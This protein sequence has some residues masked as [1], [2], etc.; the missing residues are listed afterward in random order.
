MRQRL[1]NH[2]DK[3]E[4][5]GWIPVTKLDHLV[6][7]MKIKSLKEIYHFSSHIR[8]SKIIDCFLGAFFKDEVLKI[9]R[10]QK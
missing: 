2:G 7:D 3:I 10:M 9:L 4:D 8:E 1:G 5:K 6:K